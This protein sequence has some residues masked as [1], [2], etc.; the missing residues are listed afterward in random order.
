L[1]APLDVTLTNTNG[2]TTPQNGWMI[3]G[4]CYRCSPSALFKADTFWCNLGALN[5][6]S[7]S[8]MDDDLEDSDGDDDDDDKSQLGSE[9]GGQ[10]TPST[11]FDH[12]I[13]TDVDERDAGENNAPLDSLSRDEP[14]MS[15]RLFRA[16][17]TSERYCNPKRTCGSCGFTNTNLK[18]TNQCGAVVV[19]QIRCRIIS[20][21][22]RAP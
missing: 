17:I 16:M 8:A 11:T 12:P 19:T 2:I 18:R 22:T 14:N 6:G 5:G 9:V 15:I 4:I 10:E 13:N 1:L 20:H 21:G 7:P 3:L